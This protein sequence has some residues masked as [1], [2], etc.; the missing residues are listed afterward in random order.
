MPQEIKLFGLGQQSKSSNITAMHRLN[1]YYDV[2][3]DTDKANVVA[4]GTPGTVL[5]STVSSS[6]S[7]GMHWMESNNLLYAVQRG[8]L[9]AI[10][11]N[12]TASIVNPTYYTFTVS[13]VTISPVAYSSTYSNNGCVFVAQTVTI[14]AGSG[15][16]VCSKTSGTTP[17]ASGTLTKVSGTGDSTI[18]F[19]AFTSA[20]RTLTTINPTDINGRVSMANNGTELCIVTGT[21][22]YIYNP[23]LNSLTGITALLPTGGADTVTFLDS[24]FIV[25]RANTAQF[26]IS[27]QYDGLTWNALN[28]A[29]AESNP[30]NLQAVIADKGYLALLGTSSIELWVNSGAL[31]FPF[32]R[33]NGAPSPSGLMARWSL[34]RCGDFL[35][36]L[37]KNKHGA[38]FIGQLQGYNVVQVSTPD[39]DYIINQYASPSDAV[40]F[41][42]TLNGRIYYQITFQ[43]E[44]KTWLYDVMSNA[45]SQLKSWNMT[46]HF[47]DL[48]C[49]FG[50]KLIVSD[51]ASG[52][53][54]YFS[55]Q[56]YTDNGLPIEREL[57]SG[58]LFTTGRN[59]VRVTRLRLDMEGGI[60]DTSIIGNDPKIM[61]SISRDG[62]H[63][64]GQ[65]L[66]VSI[67]ELGHYHR[68]AEWRRL[69]WARDFVFKIR[70]T[71]PVK[72][73]L[74]QGV[75]EA[76]EASK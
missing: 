34:S 16:I 15:T 68:R 5:F 50:T 65:E 37:F 22:G 72:F 18:A 62:G 59:K 64:Y 26:Y 74:M 17:S 43:S 47:G 20:T 57:T 54:Y 71:D 3:A 61:L 25:N 41:G 29:T 49:A 48:C 32:E 1:V 12:G 40:G 39:I 8:D 19:S 46:R 38:L 33:V 67:G 9:W 60:G 36:G 21:Y 53:L 4:Y 11:A 69:G 58:H 73:L 55:Q 42:Y 23:T 7:R 35:T 52:L 63:T 31:A 66:W 10:A 56:A 76:T 27:G 30:D 6:A 51:Y 13:G 14:V 2:Q 75:V 44:G 45:W 28:F 24:Y 70:M